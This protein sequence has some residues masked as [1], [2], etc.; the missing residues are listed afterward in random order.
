[1]PSPATIFYSSRRGGTGYLTSAVKIIDE[2]MRKYF[3]AMVAYRIA[4]LASSLAALQVSLLRRA[5]GMSAEDM[6]RELHRLEDLRRILS[7]SPE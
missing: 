7:G 1:M 3:E 4:A 2:S 6:D 5:D